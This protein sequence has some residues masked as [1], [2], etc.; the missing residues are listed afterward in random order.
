MTKLSDD[1]A[2]MIVVSGDF[3][4]YTKWNSEGIFKM[5]LNGNNTTKIYSE[6]AP[7]NVDGNYVYFLLNGGYIYRM[8]LSGDNVVKLSE[9]SSVGYM[10]VMDESLYFADSIYENKAN[11][12][13]IGVDG[14]NKGVL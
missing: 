11:L 5:D 14:T 1:N 6:S 3:I 2:T 12:Y 13:K 8:G 10:S 4:Y 7:F 9:G